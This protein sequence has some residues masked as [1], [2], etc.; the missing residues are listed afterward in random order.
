MAIKTDDIYS[1]SYIE[2]AGNLQFSLNAYK[3]G[4]NE[5]NAVFC[6]TRGSVTHEYIDKSKTFGIGKKAYRACTCENQVQKFL[7]RV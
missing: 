4:K 2:Y 1:W 6:L 7:T 5:A 3:I